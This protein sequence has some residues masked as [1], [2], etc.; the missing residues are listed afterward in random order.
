MTKDSSGP[1]RLEEMER[2]A[3]RQSSK[4]RAKVLQDL[5]KMDEHGVRPSKPRD[6]SEL[7]VDARKGGKPDNDND[8]S[9][10]ELLERKVCLIFGN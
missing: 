4:Q 1:F 2:D 8:Y 3:G 7:K 6:H 9:W 5:W 10:K